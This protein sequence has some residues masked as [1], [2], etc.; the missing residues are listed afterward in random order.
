[1]LPVPGEIKGFKTCFHLYTMSGQL[2]LRPIQ[3]ADF[4][5]VDRIFLALN[6]RRRLWGS[7][8]NPLKTAAKLILQTLKST[9]MDFAIS[10]WHI[11]LANPVCFLYFSFL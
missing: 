4:Q 2:F 1:M 5:M 3:K 8:L 11:M 9:L 10:A 6:R 7:M